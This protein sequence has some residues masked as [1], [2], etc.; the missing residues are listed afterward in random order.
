ML[1]IS[2]PVTLPSGADLQ[3]L[4]STMLLTALYFAQKIFAGYWSKPMEQVLVRL[5]TARLHI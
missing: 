3:G 2:Q 1:E 4:F 5:P